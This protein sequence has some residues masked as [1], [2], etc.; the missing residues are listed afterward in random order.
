VRPRL[1]ILLGLLLLPVSLLAK[2][3]VT[4]APAHAASPSANYVAALGAADRFLH[5]WQTQD[6]EAGLLLITDHAKQQ[7]SA[8]RLEKFFAP[9]AVTTRAYH[10]ARGKRLPPGAYAFPVALLEHTSTAQTRRRNSQL[11][12]VQT[13]KDEWAVDKLP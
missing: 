2:K 3:K 8:E 10:V 5:A 12:V 13:G 1:L 9:D 4:P 11:I 7:T 6:H